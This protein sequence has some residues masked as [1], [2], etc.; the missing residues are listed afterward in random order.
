VRNVTITMPDE[1]LRWAR[2]RAAEE[3]RS[4]SGLVG[5]ML[6]EKMVQEGAYAAAMEAYLSS[7]PA[8][9]RRSGPLPSRAELHDRPGLR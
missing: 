2:V 5:E 4:V 1:V 7:K 3:G 8:R 6:R 9:L